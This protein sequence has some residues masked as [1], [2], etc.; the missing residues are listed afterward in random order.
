MILLY[1][2]LNITGIPR[3]FFTILAGYVYGVFYGF[4]FAWVATI[5]GLFVSFVNIRFL[6]KESFK[7]KFGSKKFV[8]KLDVFIEKYNFWSVIVLRA[9]YIFPSSFLNYTYG[10]TSIKTHQ[11]MLGSAIG[12]IPV[13]M[14]NVVVGYFLSEGIS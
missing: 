7:K 9:A 5:A 10:I 2:A 13:V 11:Y 1:I 3:V 6:F 4:L 8:K 12:F 14:F